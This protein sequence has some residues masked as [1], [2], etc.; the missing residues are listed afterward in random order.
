MRLGLVYMVVLC[1]FKSFALQAQ[2]ERSTTPVVFDPLFW[3]DDLKL[4]QSQ[5]NE[6]MNINKEYYEGIYRA[7]NEHTGNAAALRN[8]T[9]DLLHQRS[10]KIWGTF[11]PKQKKKWMKLSS[12]Y[13]NSAVSYSSMKNKSTVRF[14]G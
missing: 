12:E 5:Y 3:K 1:V 11:Q 10:E 6:I 2:H 13:H 7:L 8:A 4:T 9:A 14:P